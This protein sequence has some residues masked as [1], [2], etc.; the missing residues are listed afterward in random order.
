MSPPSSGL[1]DKPSK[2]SAGNRQQEISLKRRLIFTTVLGIMSQRIDLIEAVIC[3]ES[4][5]KT[6]RYLNSL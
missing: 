3:I 6:R 4:L 1:T 5:Y 2:E